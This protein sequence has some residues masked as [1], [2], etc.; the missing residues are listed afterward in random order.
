[1]GLRKMLQSPWT[2]LAL[3]YLLSTINVAAFRVDEDLDSINQGKLTLSGSS[4][5]Y[6]CTF[7][8]WE[9]PTE[10]G[11]TISTTW[12]FRYHPD[13]LKFLRDVR[14][15]QNITVKDIV[16]QADRLAKLLLL[17]KRAGTVL[18]E[19]GVNWYVSAGT[20][21]GQIR[22]QTFIPWDND[23]DLGV[24]TAARGQVADW[25]AQG[26]EGDQGTIIKDEAAKK[27]WAFKVDPL[28][29][30]MA[31]AVSVEND[32][33][34]KVLL[35]DM[36]TD[37]TV[38]FCFDC[39]ATN[40]DGE[41]SVNV[42]EGM[43]FGN[44]KTNTIASQ[45]VHNS[46]IC[47]KTKC[48]GVDC[49]L[50][51]KTITMDLSRDFFKCKLYECAADPLKVYPNS[52]NL[53]EIY[54]E[55]FDAMRGPFDFKVVNSSHLPSLPAEGIASLAQM[56]VGGRSTANA[57]PFTWVGAKNVAS[58]LLRAISGKGLDDPAKE[59]EAICAMPRKF[60]TC[61]EVKDE[62]DAGTGTLVAREKVDLLPCGMTPE[63]L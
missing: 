5:W 26:A 12:A 43:D 62:H 46:S 14:E 61:K 20:Q 8:G 52:K 49:D 17:L 7:D 56:G 59:R 29:K 1:M 54:R 41:H 18:N 63:D 38:D 35:F 21:I 42:D 55:N 39:I 30:S 25:I 6:Q 4:L 60:D 45:D 22:S 3:S 13:I 23:V 48:K 57:L 15:R 16:T 44:I 50:N 31:W 10:G 19:I 28:E 37:V 32:E 58:A 34:L 40:L 11:H 36:E 53:G 47:G 24:E 33:V 2:T 9:E 27:W 51:G